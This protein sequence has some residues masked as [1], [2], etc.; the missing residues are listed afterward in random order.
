MTHYIQSL[1]KPYDS[2]V[3]KN[4]HFCLHFTQTFWSFQVII[5]FYYEKSNQNI[6]QI[7]PFC[8]PCYKVKLGRVRNDMRLSNDRVFY[9]YLN[10]NYSFNPIVTNIKNIQCML[11][12][13][14]RYKEDFSSHSL[15]HPCLIS[16]K[17]LLWLC[18]LI[19]KACIKPPPRGWTYINPNVQHHLNLDHYVSLSNL[20]HMSKPGSNNKLESVTGFNSISGT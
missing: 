14:V 4:L 13:A 18:M 17:F 11:W 16:A 7:F 5:H 15:P 9:L 6:L 2:F 10:V 8:F 19:F 1:Q 3:N 20:F 12:T